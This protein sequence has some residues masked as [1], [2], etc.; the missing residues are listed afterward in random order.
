MKKMTIIILATLVAGQVFGQT[1]K[2]NNP[3]FNSVSTNEKSVD[4]FMLISNYYTLKNNIENKKSSVFVSENPTLIQIENA[5]IN[6]PFGFFYI[7]KR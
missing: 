3:V 6:I 7:N 4:N 1:D 5:A 2:K